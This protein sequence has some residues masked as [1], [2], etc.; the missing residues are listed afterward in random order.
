M[1]E[2]N[3][4]KLYD[5]YKNLLTKRQREVFELIEFED[6]SLSEAAEEFGVSRNAVHDMVKKVTSTLNNYE[7]KLKLVSK[8]EKRNEIY[9]TLSDESLKERLVAIDFE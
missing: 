3:V 1:R 4:H 7:A 6:L 5:F 2:A 8:F 9:K